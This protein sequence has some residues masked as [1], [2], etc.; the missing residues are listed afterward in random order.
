MDDE[1]ALCVGPGGLIEVR[2]SVLGLERLRR[3]TLGVQFP[4]GIVG[5]EIIVITST[6]DAACRVNYG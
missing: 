3:L 2:F 1:F 5:H 4:L 6:S